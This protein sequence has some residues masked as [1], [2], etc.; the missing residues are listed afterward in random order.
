LRTLT[1]VRLK[2]A[3]ARTTD[4]PLVARAFKR[5]F[6]ASVQQEFFRGRNRRSLYFGDSDWAYGHPASVDLTRSGPMVTI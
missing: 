6:S 3:A 2:A 5:S 1:I 4:A